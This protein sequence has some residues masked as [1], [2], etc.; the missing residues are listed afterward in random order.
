MAFYSTLF[1]LLFL[2]YFKYGTYFVHSI[3]SLLCE[4]FEV[5]LACL[6]K[7]Y[8]LITYICSMFR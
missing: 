2:L 1:F 5:E 6:G 8:I 4:D 7:K 3:F